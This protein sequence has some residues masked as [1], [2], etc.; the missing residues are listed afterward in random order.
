MPAFHQRQPVVW[1]HGAS[2]EG[3]Y[4]TCC[5]ALPRTEVCVC[6]LGVGV[7]LR[8][9][10]QIVILDDLIAV[11]DKRVDVAPG[12]ER[13]NLVFEYHLRVMIIMIRTLD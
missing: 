9:W 4:H 12:D 2:C 8:P 11:D 5:L 13:R 3:P 10:L 7:T 6:G 1:D